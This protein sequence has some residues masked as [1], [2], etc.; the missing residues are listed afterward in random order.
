MDAQTV[1]M[2]EVAPEDIV[3]IDGYAAP[4][5]PPI[6]PF[7]ALLS[8]HRLI[9][10][11]EDT[12][13]VFE[14]MQAL[15]GKAGQ[16]Y[17]RRFVA[18]PY[19]R[20]VVDEPVR[21]EEVL[22]DRERLRAMPEGSVGRIYLDFME[23]E[24][25]TAEGLLGAAEEAGIDFKTDTQFPEYRRLFLHMDVSHDLWHVLSGYGRDA[26]G[27]VC[28]LIFTHAQSRNAGFLFIVS[29]GLLAQ[30]IDQFSF[31]S[32]KAAMEARRNSYV[33]KW[34]PGFDVEELLPMQLSEAR[35]MM[36]IAEPTF[37]NSIPEE[38]KRNLLKP[39]VRET[40]A[41]REGASKVLPAE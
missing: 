36:N 15:S 11:K 24:N 4:P 37:Y 5:A 29:L 28:N 22:S 35:R 16:R 18:T 25:L 9:R 21:L 33:T 10:N 3:W 30:K 32:L 17:F 38:M 1:G 19:G 6:R 26:L 13:Q 39:K 34:V 40:Q 27:E 7:H 8:M 2:E 41:E 20:R 12:R 31:P 14:I 23:G